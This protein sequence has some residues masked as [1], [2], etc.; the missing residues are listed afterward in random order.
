MNR[1]FFG[2]L[3]S[4]AAVGLL[5]QSRMVLLGSSRELAKPSEYVKRLDRGENWLKIAHNPKRENRQGFREGRARR[6]LMLM[7]R[8]ASTE[9][10]STKLA[11]PQEG[12][13]PRIYSFSRFPRAISTAH[14]SAST[15]TP[16]P[17]DGTRT[18]HFAMTRTFSRGDY[19]HSASLR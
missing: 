13:A 6:F 4:A 17:R 7:P 9:C 8:E 3:H 11:K 5:M 18:S 1:R 15:P 16:T 2:S 19:R 10:L 14:K 12:R